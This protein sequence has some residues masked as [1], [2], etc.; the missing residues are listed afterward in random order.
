MKY[1]IPFIETEIV[2]GSP[3]KVRR[4]IS[5]TY[6]APKYHVQLVREG[7]LSIDRKQVSHP[8]MVYEIAKELV[9]D[10]DREAF[11][12]ICLDAKL[13]VIGVNLVSMGSLDV[14]VVAPRE[15]FKV[16]ILLNASSVLCF[17]NHPSGDTEPS[18]QDIKTTLAL[19]SAG[20]ILKI[21]LLDHIIVG[22]ESYYSIFESTPGFRG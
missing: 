5:A 10:L 4:N 9:G 22:E 14:A 16:A 6:R 12:V 20:D 3:R 2:S 18:A 8:A 13:K 7:S 19:Q 15:V 17:H 11:Y 21:Q 1:E